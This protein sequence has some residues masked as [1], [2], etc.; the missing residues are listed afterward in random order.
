NNQLTQNKST[1]I[2]YKTYTDPNKK[3]T[4]NRT[5]LPMDFQ[6]DKPDSS[7]YRINVKDKIIITESGEIAWQTTFN[8]NDWQ[9]AELKVI[10]HVLAIDYQGVQKVKL[11]DKELKVL[12]VL[13]AND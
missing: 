10:N 3:M 7:E 8:D 6:Y 13:S 1:A 11:Q 12:P 4:V 5:F 9:P 2:D